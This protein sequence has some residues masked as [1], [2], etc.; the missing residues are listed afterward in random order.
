MKNLAYRGWIY[1]IPLALLI[2]GLAL[3]GMEYVRFFS[4]T[5][6]P[7]QEEFH[8]SVRLWSE[9]P[10][11]QQKTLSS[12]RERKEKKALIQRPIRDSAA[13]K[14]IQSS[15]KKSPRVL[16]LP[17]ILEENKSLRK[18]KS[19]S[20]QSP[21]NK[22]TA[23]HNSNAK[24]EAEYLRQE[25]PAYPRRAWELGQ[26]GTVLLRVFVSEAGFV[27][28]VHV[29]RSSRFK[30]LDQAALAAVKNWEF[31]AAKNNRKEKLSPSSSSVSPKGRWIKIPIRFLLEEQS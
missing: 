21:G 15:R 25:A 9:A 28:K 18:Q 24:H 12:T 1:Y 8:F 5:S 13:L 27:E 31:K 7:Q 19:P 29:H 20:L 30:L 26:E 10:A 23:R 2:N 6:S 16:S 14:K 4:T 11:L 3:Y 17:F 22:T